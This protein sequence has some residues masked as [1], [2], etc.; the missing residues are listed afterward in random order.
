LYTTITPYNGFDLWILEKE[1]DAYI[2][3]DRI[4]MLNPVIVLMI[5][6]TKVRITLVKKNVG[7]YLK[8][9]SLGCSPKQYIFPQASNFL[10]ASNGS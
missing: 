5:N 3:A 9:V 2:I 8:A 4:T 7:G 6:L 10:V 1:R